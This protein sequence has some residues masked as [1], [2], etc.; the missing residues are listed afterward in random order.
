MRKNQQGVL[1]Q[2]IHLDNSLKIRKCN[3]A[4]FEDIDSNYKFVIPASDE[5]IKDYK[6]FKSY[7][8]DMSLNIQYKKLAFQPIKIDSRNRW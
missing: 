3:F 1:G 6:E 5:A 2:I 8:G 7:A 4:R